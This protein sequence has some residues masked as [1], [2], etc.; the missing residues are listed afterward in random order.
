MTG[1]IRVRCKDPAKRELAEATERAV[2]AYFRDHPEELERIL[3]AS[4]RAL[5]R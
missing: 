2:N 3:E 4:G 1:P 5:A